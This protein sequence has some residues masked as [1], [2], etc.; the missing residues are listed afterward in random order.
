MLTPLWLFLLLYI[1]IYLAILK[2]IPIHTFQPS[3]MF[4]ILNMN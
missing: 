2:H 4:Y 3:H 1:H